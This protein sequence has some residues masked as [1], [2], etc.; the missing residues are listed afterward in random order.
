MKRKK[1]RIL[2]RIGAV[3]LTLSL[4]CV[5]L[6]GC[7]SAAQP[8]SSGEPEDSGVFTGKVIS[9][10]QSRALIAQTK[11]GSE[12]TWLSLEGLDLNDE[13]GKTIEASAI[14]PGMIVDVAFGG[15]ILEIY[16][17]SLES[18]TALKVVERGDDLV[19][20]YQT[21]LDDLYETDPG[22]NSGITMMAFDLSEVTNLSP[23]EKMALM[24]VMG[25][26]HQIETIS[27]TFDELCEQSYIDREQLYFEK[28]LLFSISNVQAGNTSF[29]FDAQKWRGGLGAYFFNDCTAKKAGGNWS[30][31]VG[32]EAIS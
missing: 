22:L 23:S 14:V 7:S 2:P 6:A 13:N 27:G 18:P 30:Y 12:L 5:L 29:T 21:V 9:V 20:L 28:G 17:C 4:A 32:S 31:T 19:G 1:E 26:N 24:Y 8:S 25:G 3:I 16:P 11:G 15:V 10:D